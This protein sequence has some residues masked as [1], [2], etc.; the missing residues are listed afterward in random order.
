M[1]SEKNTGTLTKEDIGVKERILKMKEGFIPCKEKGMSIADISEEFDLSLSTV[2]KNLDEIAIE[3]GVSRDELL[4][5]GSYTHKTT[6][7][8]EILLKK[9]IDN[10]KEIHAILEKLL[11]DCSTETI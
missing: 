8:N 2:Y 1:K 6:N 4:P 5:R 11:N 7:Q 3:N 10:L 9:A